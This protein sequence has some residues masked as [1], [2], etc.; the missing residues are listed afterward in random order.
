MGFDF[1]IT[2]DVLLYMRLSLSIL[3]AILAIYLNILSIDYNLPIELCIAL[4]DNSNYLA[5]LYFF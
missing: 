3:I 4:A 2:T 1:D 5:L